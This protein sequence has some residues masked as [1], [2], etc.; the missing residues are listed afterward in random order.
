MTRPEWLEE[1]AAA[2]EKAGEHEARIR[3]FEEEIDSAEGR[4]ADLRDQL[5]EIEDQISDVNDEISDT[6]SECAEEEEA[7]REAESALNELLDNEPE[8]EDESE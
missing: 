8:E 5:S 3:K 1:V 6:E 2:R 4:K 7:L